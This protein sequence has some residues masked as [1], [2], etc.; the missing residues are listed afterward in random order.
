MGIRLERVPLLNCNDMI[1]LKSIIVEDELQS[2]VALQS[3]LDLHTDKL[4]VEGIFDSVRKANGFMQDHEV[5]LVFLDIE[6]PNESGFA[7]FENCIH[8][9]IKIIF[10]TAYNHYAIQAFKI[11]AV[12]YLLKP[13]DPQELREA[14]EKAIRIE[15]EHRLTE[16][17]KILVENLTHGNNRLAIAHQGGYDMVE[18]AD[19]LWLEAEINYTT[20]HLCQGRRVTV[21]K[22][23]RLFEDA[24]DPQNFYRI[25]RGA[26]VNLG[27]IVRL[28][29]DGGLTVTLSDSTVLPVADSRKEGFFN[30]FTRI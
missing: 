25:S 21:A 9:N 7:L 20:L 10:T 22:T 27:R 4:S 14:I 18:M 2:Q 26:I 5:D 3:M 15:N 30:Y 13:I 24:L 8:K 16:A 12:D 19:I 11:S 17:Y 29:R 28:H 23:L 6:L 1:S